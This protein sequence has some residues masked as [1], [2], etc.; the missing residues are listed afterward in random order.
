MERDNSYMVHGNHDRVASRESDNNE[1]VARISGGNRH[2]E[3]SAM[4]QSGAARRDVEARV[5]DNYGSGGGV[6]SIL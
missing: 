3:S 2:N 1:I 4:N 6:G 5:V